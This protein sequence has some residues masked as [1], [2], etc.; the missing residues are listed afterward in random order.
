MSAAKERPETT[1]ARVHADELIRLRH[2]ANAIRLDGRRRVASATAGVHESRFRGRGVDYQESRAYQAGDDIRNM[3]WRVTARTGVAHTKLY[4]EERERPVILVLDY[5]PT[6]YFGTRQRFK[7]VQ[8]AHVAALM[9][10]STVRYGDR[11]GAFVFGHGDH[12]ELR[13]AGG[14]RGALRLIRGLVEWTNTVPTPDQGI[15]GMGDA[16][17]RLRRVARPGSLIVLISDFYSLD[18]DTERH[19]TALRQHNDVVACR[20]LDHLELDVPPA[21]RYAVSDG[22]RRGMLNLVRKNSRANY[23]QYF[24]DMSDRVQSLTVRR[25]IP[26]VTIMTD[27]NPSDVLNLQ[28]LGRRRGA[29]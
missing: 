8:M 19:L 4:Q 7:S 28:L 11:I 26:L 5:N 9:A 10:W 18:D 21:G 22:A 25:N 24:Q 2:R 3:D 14:R 1:G 15:A 29:A 6:A 23:Q 17:K 13:P 12:L 27:D 20:V 16:V